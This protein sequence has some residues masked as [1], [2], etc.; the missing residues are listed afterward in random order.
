MAPKVQIGRRKK[1]QIRWTHD[2]AIIMLTAWFEKSTADF[3]AQV[4]APSSNQIQSEPIKAKFQ[5]GQIRARF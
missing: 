2:P 5:S 3:M 4:Q 1:F